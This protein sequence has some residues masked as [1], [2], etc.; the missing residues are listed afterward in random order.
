MTAGKCPSKIKAPLAVL[1]I[2]PNRWAGILFDARNIHKCLD[3]PKVDEWLGRT[4]ARV[5]KAFH[6]PTTKQALHFS[7]IFSKEKHLLAK[8]DLHKL[9]NKGSFM[10]ELFVKTYAV[11][12]LLVFNFECLHCPYHTLNGHQNILM[13]RFSVATF[14]LFRISGTVNYLHLFDERTLS[15]LARA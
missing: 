5:K 10:N 14:F 6:S 3:L 7:A 15:R 13:N 11:F 2:W 12:F 4:V 9:P 8:K 1:T